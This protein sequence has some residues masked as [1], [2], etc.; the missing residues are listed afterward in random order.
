MLEYYLYIPFYKILHF[1]LSS[2][3]ALVHARHS[4]YFK[5]IK[6][7]K[8]D[9]DLTFILKQQL[10]KK[11]R[12][13]F[14]LKLK[15]VKML[16]PLMG[17]S[18]F[19]DIPNVP[20]LISLA[21]PIEIKR[22]PI[23]LKKINYLKNETES[24]KIIF[25][26]KLFKSDIRNLSQGLSS[27]FGKISYSIGLLNPKRE[28]TKRDLQSHDHFFTFLSEN[29]IDSEH[30]YF[31]ENIFKKLKNELVV[32]HY[33]NAMWNM[34]RDDLVLFQEMSDSLSDPLRKLII[35]NI[36]WELWGIYTQLPVIEDYT[37]ALNHVLIF[38]ENLKLLRDEDADLLKAC[39]CLI[40]LLH[41]A[42]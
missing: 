38:V 18:N 28:I 10:E 36:R 22:D 14:K 40:N 29:F 37:M 25:L 2:E 6:L 11:D 26:L 32:D 7:L 21:N 24:E 17:E 12:D 5:K 39:D 4:F 42:V 27:R 23:L 9:I 13:H 8:S 35:N 34:K 31:L 30:L 3:D 16:I 19:I 15:R 33:F 41:E 20:Y 1:L